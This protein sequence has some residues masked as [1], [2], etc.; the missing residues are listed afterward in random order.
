MK[1]YIYVIEIKA[2][3]EDNTVLDVSNNLTYL[4]ITNDYDNSVFPIME[5]STL[6]SPK[7]YYQIN[8]KSVV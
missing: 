6:I 8:R 2:I 5:V 3:L 4:A 1:T 7:A